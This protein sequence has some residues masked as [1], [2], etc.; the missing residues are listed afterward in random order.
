M[1]AVIDTNH[2]LRIAAARERSPLFVAWRDRRFDLAMSESMLT[3]LA[4][5][6]MRPKTQ[7]FLPAEVGQRCLTDLQSRAIWVVPASEFP[8]CRDPKDDMVIATAVAARAHF[9]VTTDRDLLDDPRLVAQLN[10]EWSIRV[11]LPAE[12]LSAFG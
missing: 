5:V 7:R 12:L 11:I 3:E 9:I 1:R 10:D 4:G 8:H 2:L 6:M